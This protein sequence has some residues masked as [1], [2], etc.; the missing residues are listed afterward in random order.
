MVTKME[1][2]Y[3]KVKIK[4]RKP[5]ITYETLWVR[6]L[7]ANTGEI[8]NIPIFTKRF[9]YGDVVEYDSKTFEVKK[10]ISNGGY[11]KTKFAKYEGDPEPTIEKLMDDG[12]IVEL[13]QGL[14]A[15][16]KAKSYL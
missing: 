8:N 11:T 10:L 9:K 13:W 5:G 15:V 14:L 16:T 6:C 7:S 3:Q 1:N 4:I 12:Y 2:N